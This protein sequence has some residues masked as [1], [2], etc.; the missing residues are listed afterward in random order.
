MFQD[1]E[2]AIDNLYHAA[3]SLTDLCE[4]GT[5]NDEP[6]LSNQVAATLGFG[7]RRLANTLETMAQLGK[8]MGSNPADIEEW[9]AA[10]NT[11]R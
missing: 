5:Y 10:A 11:L 8:Q 3:L 4:N 7:A 6:V 9:T 1:F 2:R